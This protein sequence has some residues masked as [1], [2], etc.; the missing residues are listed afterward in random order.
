MGESPPFGQ[1]FCGR[2]LPKPL[3]LESTPGVRLATNE[4]N[5]ENRR[6]Q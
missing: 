5:Y 4:V 2:K 6:G 1:R 3:D